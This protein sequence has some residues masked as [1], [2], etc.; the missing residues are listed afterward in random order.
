MRSGSSQN[1]KGNPVMQPSRSASLA[2]A[3]LAA[4]LALNSAE[5]R[6]ITV[7]VFNNFS[8]L[9][10]WDAND[11]L[12][13]TASSSIYEG[14]YRFDTTLTPRPQLAES[15]E[16][17][18]DGLV[19]TF[20]LRRGVKFHDGSDFNA[21]AVK[22]NFDRGMNPNSGLTRR[23]FFSFVDKV[24]TPDDF[25]VRF[26]LKKPT[27]GF[28]ARLSNGTATMICP[29]LLARADSKRVTAYEACGTGP[30]MLK[31]FSP[32]EELHVVKNPNYRVAGLPKL[33][34]IRWVPVPENASRAMMLQTG[35]AQFITPVPFEQMAVLEKDPELTI[36][37]SPSVVTRYISFNQTKKPFD[38]IRVRK[39][40]SLAIN[41]N[42][43]I[44]VAYNG[45]AVPSTGYLPPQIEGGVDFGPFPTDVKKA[46]ELLKEAGYPNGFKTSIWAGYNDGKSLKTLQFLQQQLAQIGIRAETRALEAGQRTLIYGAKTPEESQHEMYV[47][48]WTNS[49]AEPDWG[50]RPLLDSRSMPPALNNE[51]Y[52]RNPKV[53][54]LFDQ[55]VAETNVEKRI[56]LYKEL[57]ELV[58]ADQPWAPLAFE[59]VT[60]GAS[61]HLKNFRLMPDSSLDF[62]KAEW[63]E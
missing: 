46:R 30:Y 26:T 27:A 52:Y 5:A 14:L 63:T 54:A 4:L 21:Q 37:K 36:L 3:A 62:Y 18:P 11:N 41:R 19:Y 61:K 31:R 58:H 15:Y 53:D 12:S 51:S 8:T 38:D 55:A 60:G 43:L 45:Y 10:S 56:A 16:V 59:M 7:A 42:A 28:I 35:E 2:A 49:A 9:D 44:K 24:E 20:K 40:I 1:D 34:G 22:L 39:A 6:E 23:T 50:L 33:D 29:S 48:G 25:T 17:S 57:Q 32:A 47:I 13:R